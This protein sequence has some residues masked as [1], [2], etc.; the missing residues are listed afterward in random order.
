MKAEIERLHI[1]L[2]ID[3]ENS[4]PEEPEEKAWLIA[5]EEYGVPISSIAKQTGV[6]PKRITRTIAKLRKNRERPSWRSP[7]LKEDR[8]AQEWRK[9]HDEDG[10]AIRE[11]A[12]RVGLHASSVMRRIRTA[13]SA[14][15]GLAA[16]VDV[17]SPAGRPRLDPE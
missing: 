8:I 12:R 10:V 6:D 9:E 1:Q 2:Q 15:K 7:K 4:P 5:H 17:G 13:R 14:H 11:I 16:E 3:M